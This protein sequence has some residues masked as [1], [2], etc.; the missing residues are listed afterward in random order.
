MANARTAMST[1]AEAAH[2]NPAGIV[3]IARPEVLA[4]WQYSHARL[5]L[6]A[7][8]AG[9][10]D[11]HGTSLG[12]AAPFSIDTYRLAVGLAMYVPDRQLARVELEPVSEP[13]YARLATAA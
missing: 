6:D 13:H 11:A 7:R 8:D 1:G 12:L 3:G 2:D 10:A 9:V 4:G 5:T